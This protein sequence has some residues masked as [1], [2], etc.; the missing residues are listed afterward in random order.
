MP[1]TPP[2]SLKL[3]TKQKPDQP[4]Y[5]TIDKKAHKGKEDIFCINNPIGQT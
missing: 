1:S 4:S 2:E 5:A 3:Q